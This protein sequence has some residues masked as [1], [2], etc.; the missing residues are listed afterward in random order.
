MENHAPARRQTI[1]PHGLPN[2]ARGFASVI[3]AIWKSVLV[4]SLVRSCAIALNPYRLQLPCAAHQRTPVSPAC[5][6]FA[7]HA[8]SRKDVDCTGGGL[9]RP[10][11]GMDDGASSRAKFQEPRGIDLNPEGTFFAVAGK[12]TQLLGILNRTHACNHP[13][14]MF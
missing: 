1:A 7:T 12:K 8:C 13:K 9:C 11:K 3:D 10:S 14:H 4:L 6:C 2:P 5:V